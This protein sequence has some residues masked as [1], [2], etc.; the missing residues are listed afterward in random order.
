MTNLTFEWQIDEFMIYCQ[1]KQLR[2][3]TMQS[4]EQALRLFERWCREE[5]QIESVDEIKENDIRRYIKDLQERGKYTVY[6]SEKQ[7]S[8]NHPDHRRDYRQKVSVSTINNYLRDIKVFFNWLD[9]S[10]V[11]RNNPMR[12]VKQLKNKRKPKE[13]LSDD[14]FKKLITSL[15]KS[16]FSEHRDLAM[17]VLLFDTGMRLGECSR[18]LVSDLDLYGRKIHLRAEETKGCKDRVV[19]FSQKTEKTLRRWLQFKDRYTETDYV[20]PSRRDGS[21]VEVTGFESN[22]SRYLN[23]FGIKEKVSPH[24]LRNNFAKRCLMNGMDLYSL[25]RILGHSSVTVTEEA[26]LDLTDE[27]LSMRYQNF[28]PMARVN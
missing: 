2:P 19:Y 22:F 16:Y 28:S 11:L 13:F 7:K 20:F 25:S 21:P 26:Y 15:D 6:I 4:Y 5:R 18:L 14:S 8:T 17:I 24:C 1:S 10:C 3:K 27:D 12:N 9:E 23:R